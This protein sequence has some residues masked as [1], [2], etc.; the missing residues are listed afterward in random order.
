MMKIVRHVARTREMR[1]ACK[2]LVRKPEWTWEYE[3]QLEG[4]Y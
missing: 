4:L 3:L 2:I 1:N